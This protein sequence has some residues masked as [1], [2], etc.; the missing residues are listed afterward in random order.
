MNY[1][2]LG[3]AALGGTA[4]YFAFGFLLFWLVPALIHESRKYPAVFR[5]KEKLLCQLDWSQLC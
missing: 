4:A 2:R 3:L 5:P 1:L